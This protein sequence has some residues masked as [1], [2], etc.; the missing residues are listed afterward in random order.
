LNGE[1]GIR[2]FR[3][4]DEALDWVFAKDQVA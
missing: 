2:V 4:I 3:N 1:K